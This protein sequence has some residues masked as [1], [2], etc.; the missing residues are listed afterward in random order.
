MNLLDPNEIK[1]EK[2]AT[3]DQSQRLIHALSE[4]EARINKELNL[5]RENAKI[6][7]QKIEAETTAFIESQKTRKEELVKEVTGLE[8][9]RSEALKPIEVVK[10]EADTTM[11]E[12]KKALSRALQREKDAEALHE[13]NLD[14]ADDLKD[15]KEE[16]HD[17]EQRVEKKENINIVEE[18]RLKDSA[19]TLANKW[20]AFHTAVNTSNVNFENKEKRIANTEK[21][22]DIRKA[23]L[24]K[25]D[26]LQTEHR[27]Q[28]RDKY[29]TLA[30]AIEEAKKKY[31][32]EV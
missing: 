9:R 19:N 22:L 12:A 26:V 18:R 23:E 7:K 20:V 31:N 17:R 13:A 30:R 8:A 27:R 11:E 21:V 3:A 1:E 28:I 2:K 10:I 6:E 15:K 32:I 16:L 29:Q 4:E 14:L 25:R 24:D 5:L